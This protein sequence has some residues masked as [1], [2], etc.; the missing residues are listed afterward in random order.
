M[1]TNNV[2]GRVPLVLLLLRLSVFLVMAV[3]TADKFFKPTHTSAVFETFYGIGGVGT[4]VVYVL[5]VLQLVIVVGFL[6][7]FLKTWTYGAVLLMHGASTLISF[8]RYLDPLATPNILFFT[9]WPMFA[10]CFGLFYLRDLDTLFAVDRRSARKP[11]Q[12]NV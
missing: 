2:A 5:G 4:G 10:A 7:G 12:I 3:W 6:V 8:P 9:A 11:K 1:T